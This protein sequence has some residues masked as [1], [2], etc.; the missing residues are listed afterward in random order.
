MSARAV[1]Y[2]N[3]AAVERNCARLAAMSPALCAV[4]K[5]NGYGHGAVECARAAL[6][7]GASW[8]AVAAAAEARELRD[9]GV[10]GPI[11][12]MGALSRDEVGGALA[13]GADVVAWHEELLGWARESPGARVH[14]KLD[15]GMGRFGTRDGALADR[16][17]ALVAAAPELELAGVMTH[18][19]TAE[20]A[21]QT[22]LRQQLER[23]AAWVAPLRD[24]HPGLLVHGENSAALLGC[25]RARFDMVR[26][27]GAVYG[28]D[29]FGVDPARHGLEAALSLHS[30]VASCTP[31]A[32]GQSAGYG[33]AFIA[34]EQ[35]ELAVIPVG[36]G[37]G[38]RRALSNNAEVLID[39]RRRPV[40]GHVSMD[41]LTADLGL[42]SGVRIGM[43]A[44]LLGADGAERITA[45]EVA[46]RQ[47]T[48]NYE[49]TCAIGPRVP[50]RYHRDGP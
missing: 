3:L 26:A 33:R 12:V 11:L 37:D 34:R 13:A 25:G 6:A 38:F 19:A 21:D 2:V 47:G 50:R 40:V 18:L 1:A 31:C 4:V 14:V 17:V 23:F 10:T 45:E 22:F 39:G 5:A 29:P 15:T 36:Y 30:W 16:L 27:G 41:N 42:D 48:I 7:G 49:V 43:R 24:R 44:V 20:A 9:A 8:L 28:L 35:T 32:P 46:S